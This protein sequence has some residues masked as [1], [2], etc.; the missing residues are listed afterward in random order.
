MHQPRDQ[1]TAHDQH[2]GNEDHDL[3]QRDQQLEDHAA[4]RDLT[5][6]SHQRGGGHQ[7][8]GQDHGE[9]LEDEP[10]DRD[11]AAIRIENVVFLQG[12]D[13]HD[14]AGD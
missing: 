8:Q 14:G 6:L 11:A 9:I 1:P 3:G 2:D 7:H 12:P 4:R 5:A 10:A 13:A